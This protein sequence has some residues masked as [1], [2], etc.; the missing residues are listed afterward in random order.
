MDHTSIAEKKG[1]SFRLI[2]LFLFVKQIIL[3][4]NNYFTNMRYT[5]RQLEVFV[6]IA[7]TENVSLA[8]RTLNMTQSAAS[9]ALAGLEQAFGEKLFDRVGKR[10]KLN[11]CGRRLL[12]LAI[13]LL[14]R[15]SEIE[16]LLHDDADFGRLRIGATLTIGNYLA[17]LIIAEL[18]QR[19]P[20][21]RAQLQVHNTATVI[22][23]VVAHEIDIGLIEGE[24]RHPEIAVERW[25][26]DELVVFCAPQ[27]PL[28][29]R[30]RIT[31]PDLAGVPWILRE[32]GSSTRETLEQALRHY[33]F[34]LD[35]RL[36]LEHTEAVKR[37]VECGLGLGCISRLALRD[38]FR[39][40]SLVP[41]EVNELDLRRRFQ[42]LWRHDK[43]QNRAMRIFLAYCRSLTV[44][45]ERSDEIAL[46]AI[47]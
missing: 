11:D 45:V 39:R 38:A 4:S 16:S 22:E 27:H 8:I 37:A 1:I 28:T 7:R 3:L 31:L 13:E 47:A 34:P 32:M 18:L 23:Q 26:D 46:P 2:S 12:P 14:D 21:S 20:G 30:D 9:A 36:E 35:V 29:Q 43:Y 17:T 41:L 42:F 44:G 6:E 19:Y 25:V 24:C 40:G 15:A 33:R 10:V 5:L